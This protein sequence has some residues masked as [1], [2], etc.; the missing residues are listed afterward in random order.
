MESERTLSWESPLERA[1]ALQ[2]TDLPPYIYWWTHTVGVINKGIGLD[3][4]E[5]AIFA[6]V[7]REMLFLLI[8]L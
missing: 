1:R 3:L 5:P 7:S 4:S 8:L 6:F 2:Q